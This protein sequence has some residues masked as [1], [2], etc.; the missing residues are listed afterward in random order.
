MILTRFASLRFTVTIG[1]DGLAETL[2]EGRLGTEEAGHQEVE[3]AP[4]LEDV[5]LYRSTGKDET[6]HSLDALD[7]LRQLGLRVL[8]DVTFIEDAVVPVDV[9]Q[10][11]D[12]VPD[13]LI[14]SN[15]DIVGLQLGQELVPFTRVPGV[16]DRLQVL[17]VLQDLIVP[18]TRERRW[19]HDE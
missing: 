1:K 12:V 15:H 7:G 17:R 10:A 4:Q 18:M 2:V 3:E 5:V 13:D 6:V 8:D 11:R 14:R 19:A 9:L 16:E